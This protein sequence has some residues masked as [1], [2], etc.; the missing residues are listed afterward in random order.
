MRSILQ[1]PGGRWSAA[2][3]TAGIGV[4]LVLA[5][6]TGLAAPA[7]ARERGA[8]TTRP[9]AAKP[10]G[11]TLAPTGR[12]VPASDAVPADPKALSPRPIGDDKPTGNDKSSA[13]KVAVMPLEIGGTVPAGRPALEEAVRRGIA[14]V[15]TAPVIVGS[16]V[17]STLNAA[18]V[19]VACTEPACFQAVGRTLRARH[20][21]AGSIDRKGAEFVVEFKVIAAGDGRVLDRQSNRCEAAECSVAELTRLTVLELARGTL[22]GD[23][24]AANGTATS[25]TSVIPASAPPVAANTSGGTG[26]NG[27]AGGDVV[28]EVASA[29]ERPRFFSSWRRWYPPVAIAGGVVAGAV[30]GYLISIDGDETKCDSENICGRRWVS[31]GWG[32]GV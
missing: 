23:A 14:V 24:K 20:L 5:P 30:G 8:K 28:G 7:G 16:E 25:G 26:T 3:L 1:K 6:A 15:T 11:G 9:G 22:S 21:V 27:G 32:I 2:L 18:G 12:K 31:T 29:P 4:G 19:R 17:T 10:A 13:D